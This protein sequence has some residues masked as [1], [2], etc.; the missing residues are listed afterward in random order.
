MSLINGGI[1]KLQ[2]VSFRHA[3]ELL[4]NDVSAL[5]AKAPKHHN[6]VKGADGLFSESSTPQELLNHVVDHYHETLQQ[7]PEALEY[8]DKRG[9][10]NT[11]LIERFKLGYANRSLAYRLP[12][13]NRPVGAV[14]RGKLQEVRILR[15]SGHKHLNGSIVVPIFDQNQEICELYGRKILG[16]K[17]RKGTAQ[18]CYLPGPH[19]GV[20]NREGLESQEEIILC[21]ALLDAMSFWVHGYKNVTAS[22]GTSGFTK[23]HLSVLKACGAKRILIAYDRDEAGNNAAEKLAKQL[24][25]EGFACYRLLFPKAMDANQYALEVQPANKSLGIV[26]RSAQWMGEGQAPERQLYIETANKLDTSE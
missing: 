12:E 15:K 7:S 25:K 11:E 24:Q 2:G 14:I 23:D 10:K 17:L 13:K 6:A 3:V 21:E 9:L 19:A 4:R 20:W 1:T 18:H 8:L 5:A 22:Y 26:I 16:T